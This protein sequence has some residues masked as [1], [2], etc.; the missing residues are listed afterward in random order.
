MFSISEDPLLVFKENPDWIIP[1]H[2]VNTPA[3]RFQILDEL[4]Y[5]EM[6]QQRNYF[7]PTL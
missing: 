3:R 2:A 5:W 4:A 1:N 7:W 6:P